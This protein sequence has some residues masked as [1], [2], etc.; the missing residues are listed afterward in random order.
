MVPGADGLTR[1]LP[2]PADILKFVR[3]T[4]GPA[5]KR[6]IA[7]AFGL[8]GADR[9]ALK[10]VLR[11]MED[12]GALDRTPGRAFHAGGALP[13]VTVIRVAEIAADGAAFAVP[14]TWEQAAP[15]PRIRVV[16]RSRQGAPGIGDRMLA[17][18]EQ[19]GTGY[20]AHPMKRLASRAEAMLGVL[21]GAPG[22]WFLAPTDKKARGEMPV[23][24]PGEA[25]PGDL[26]LAE[27]HG[28]GPQTTARVTQVLGDPFAPRAFSLIA[29]HAKRIPHVFPE[30][31]LADAAEAAT[32]ALGPREDLTALPFLT[33]DPADARDHDDA[34]WAEAD[35]DRPG[36]WRAMVAIADVSWYVRPHSAL[37][38]EAR[39]RGN[40][41]YFPD[42]VVPMLPEALSAD[43]CS[44]VAGHPRAVLACH[45][46]IGPG[47]KVTSHR[48]ARATI[49]CVTNIAYEDAQ[50]SIDAGSGAYH[51]I[52]APLWAAWR[53]LDAARAA[54]AP[55]DL[56]L[57]ERRVTLDDQGRI[58]EI[59]TRV[60]LD[61]HRL[62]E[63]YMIAA[64]VAA[65][66][67]LDA[68]KAPCVYRDH[69]AP[70]REKLIAF[71]DYLKTFGVPF[72]LG[73][74]MRPATFNRVLAEVKGRD[75]AGA[76]G[77]QVLRTQTQAYY[78]ATNTGHFGLALGQYA[79]FT[80][81]IRRYS[82]LIVH[83]ALVSAYGL[84][85]GGLSDDEVAI[86]PRTCEH[87]SQTERRA[88]EA[89]RDT[90]DRYIA[91]HLGDRVGEIVDARVTG[92][93]K[94]GLFAQ[95]DGVGGDG[96]LPMSALGDERF[97]YD[98]TARV[99]EGEHSGDRYTI[100]QRL[101]LRLAEANP[102]TGALRFEQP[103]GA[104]GR[105]PDQRRDRRVRRGR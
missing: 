61:A 76:I 78:A 59:G 79:H 20:R 96:I 44:L 23:S 90:M 88:M 36:H 12:A 43:A 101:K 55:L 70:G 72:A 34:V 62:I 89:E 91:R 57:P 53:A 86:L 63:E 64:N 105:A 15:P 8:N 22:R 39:L 97:H 94:F 10:A 51:A 28:R 5:G 37:D 42:R 2:S 18:I 24:D 50:A 73:Q 82:D 80:S 32:R 25:K 47:G 67:A 26:V 13:K 38:R 4:P 98:E 16:E 93:A 27:P 56:D 84:G 7:R 21:Q 6:E 92:V 71:R 35:P 65:A 40:S 81:P 19:V 49:R 99:I 17:R 31:V 68:R 48:F 85:E 103:E 11:E 9:I 58:A 52:L 29:I 30:A 14:D 104:Y 69:E 1:V 75:E 66:Q 54:R 102:I 41:V 77:E 95:V 33:I 46:G 3:D 100:G 83:R 45:L 60:R 87:I 74:V